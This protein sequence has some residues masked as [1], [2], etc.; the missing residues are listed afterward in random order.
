MY[1]SALK[2]YLCILWKVFGCTLCTSICV[3]ISCPHL[4]FRALFCLLDKCDFF[5]VVIIKSKVAVKCIFCFLFL[6]ECVDSPFLR[7]SGSD[8]ENQLLC[9]SQCLQSPL[10]SP[11]A[12][13]QVKRNDTILRSSSVWIV[14]SVCYYFRSCCANLLTVKL[15]VYY[16]KF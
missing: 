14:M 12:P 13:R 11:A 2:T 5:I 15:P 3:Y 9:N 4:C 6:V 1:L 10:S 8:T 7:A 16:S